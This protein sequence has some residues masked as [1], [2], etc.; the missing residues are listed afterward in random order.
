MCDF[1]NKKV[2]VIGLARSGKAAA[3]ILSGLGA[4]VTVTDNKKKEELADVLEEL[5]DYKL[6]VCVGG[7][8]AVDTGDTE[9]IIISPGVPFNIP[10]VQSALEKGIPVWSELELAYRL[11]K[12]TLIAITGTNGK[13]TTTALTGHIFRRAGYPVIIAGN[14]GSPLIGEVV[15]STKRH[16][17]VVEVSSFQLEGVHS[18]KP[19][20]AVL[21]NLTPDHLDRHG[22]MDNY[23]RIKSRIFAYQTSEDYTVLNYDDEL[24]RPLASQTSAR[25]LFFSKDHNLEEGVYVQEGN[26]VACI[27]GRRETICNINELGIPGEHNLENALAAVASAAIMRVNSREVGSSLKEFSG[28][29]H[30]LEHAGKLEGVTFINDSKGTNPEATLKALQAFKSPVILIAGGKN[31]GSDFCSLASAI[32]KRVKAVLLVGEAAPV[33]RQ[34]LLDRG[35][36]NITL[37]NDFQ[38]VVSEAFKLAESGDVVLMSPACASWDMFKNYEERGESFKRQ[39]VLLSKKVAER[40]GYQDGNQEKCFS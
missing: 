40:E 7:Y 38:K 17:I 32:C 18:F 21:L 37:V 19:K 29:P 36:T 10:P 39:V 31:K 9:L 27:N 30:R 1:K 34:A 25:V 4:D 13:T 5:K 11:C 26:I 22:T 14:I 23:L 16:I 35:F 20:V 6:N 8:P 2:L 12:G 3:K 24:I 15:K 33:M 28:V